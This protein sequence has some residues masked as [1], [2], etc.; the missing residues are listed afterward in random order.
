MWTSYVRES[1]GRGSPL[2]TQNAIFL[3]LKE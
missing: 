2:C 3:L 1:L